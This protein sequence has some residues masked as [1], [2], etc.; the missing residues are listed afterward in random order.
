MQSVELLFG[1][2]QNTLK[3]IP[4]VLPQLGSG[5]AHRGLGIHQFDGTAVHGDLA[6]GGM[7]HL[8]EHLALLDMGIVQD[9]LDVH[10]GTCGDAVGQYQLGGLVGGQI[11]DPLLNDLGNGILI[12]QTARHIHEPG[13]GDHVR[14]FQHLIAELFV[15]LQLRN[16]MIP[17]VTTMGM[18]LGSMVGSTVLIE[19]LF[20]IPGLGSVM[21]N[22]ISNRDFMLVANGVLI[23][24][25]FVAICNLVVDIL[26]GIIDPR[27]R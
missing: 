5:C 15:Q 4:V 22:G 11:L 12:G 13:I 7:I 16:S 19:S 26:Y 8:H 6:Q 10:N 24:S 25:I 9:L 21:M 23:I 2:A 17:I 1:H 18:R 14:A 3:D 27:T 20:V